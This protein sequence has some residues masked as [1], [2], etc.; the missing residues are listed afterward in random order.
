[1]EE[2][3][4]RG[5]V[6]AQGGG[7]VS[8]LTDSF[9]MAYKTSLSG[10]YTRDQCWVWDGEVLLATSRNVFLLSERCWGPGGGGGAL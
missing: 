7:K 6:V 1:M 4:D 3:E 8:G 10:C 2:F 5:T 9:L